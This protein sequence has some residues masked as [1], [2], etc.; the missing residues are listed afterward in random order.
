[1][2]STILEE[3][4]GYA[5]PAIFIFILKDFFDAFLFKRKM[6]DYKNIALWI[7]YFFVDHTIRSFSSFNTVIS[8]VYNT[9]ILVIVC[10]V[11]YIDSMKR[12]ILISK[13][14]VKSTAFQAV[15]L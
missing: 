7:I 8:M 1:M 2:N 15:K 14:K 6:Q 4:L 13:R 5:V 9:I 10:R 3:I 12:I 11:L